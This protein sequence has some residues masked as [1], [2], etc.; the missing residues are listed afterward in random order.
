LDF[1]I[2]EV[3]FTT[4]VGAEDGLKDDRTAFFSYWR[5][6]IFRSV[7]QLISFE[8]QNRGPRG[9]A[10]LTLASLILYFCAGAEGP[11][12]SYARQVSNFA[13]LSRIAAQGLIS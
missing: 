12:V 3:V 9:L 10:C 5:P 11:G 2:G 6:G 13:S 7:F 8:G 4:M 1:F